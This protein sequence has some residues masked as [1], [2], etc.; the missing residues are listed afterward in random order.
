MGNGGIFLP[1]GQLTRRP[2][3][4]FGTGRGVPFTRGF[5]F[6]TCLRV[7]RFALVTATS[8]VFGRRS[9]VLLCN[10]NYVLGSQKLWK[11]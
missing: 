8:L 3:W 7:A 11:T 10:K 1:F 6:G 4:P 9:V 5:T 2:W